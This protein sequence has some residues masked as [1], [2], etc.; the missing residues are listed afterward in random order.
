MC[1]KTRH[2]TAILAMHGL[3]LIHQN[4][5]P[6]NVGFETDQRCVLCR[7]CHLQR[8]RRRPADPLLQRLPDRGKRFC[9]S[10]LMAP[11]NAVRFS[12]LQIQDETSA[13]VGHAC[14]YIPHISS[15]PLCIAWS[16][17]CDATLVYVHA[18][19]G[20]AVFRRKF[21][22]RGLQH[23]LLWVILPKH[24]LLPEHPHAVHLSAHGGCCGVCKPKRC[25][26]D[27]QNI[28]NL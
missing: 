15:F 26:H 19:T 21:E 3:H 24:R 1:I 7:Q 12:R 9:C 18:R 14:A 16:L 13:E 27:E 25:R 17:T 6:L 20:V 8:L 5:L 23:S 28:H 10:I 11:Y 4:H 2:T 22:P